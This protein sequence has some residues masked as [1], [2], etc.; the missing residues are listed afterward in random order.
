MFGWEFPPHISGGLGTACFG[1]TQALARRNVAMTFV[2]PRIRGDAA[3]SH[4]RLVAAS[5]IP[6]LWGRERLE[7]FLRRLDIREVDA[8]LRPYL[9]PL[10]YE[11]VRV[12]YERR[13]SRAGGRSASILDMSGEYGST[14]MA[15]IAR[16]SEVAEALARRESFEVIHVHD[17]MTFPAGIRAQC[18][19]GKPLVAHVHSLEFDR[20]G[21]N[22]NADVYR[23]E[24]L[25]I[26]AAD[27]II[28]V[29]HYTR[30]VLI[31]RYGADPD[32]ITVVHNAVACGEAERIYHVP[33][34][35][36][37]KVV[38]FLGRV[39]FQKGPDYFVEAAA[40]VLQK[41]PDAV[42]VMAGAGDMLPRMIERVGQLRIGRHF[43]FTGFLRGAEVE[44]MYAATDL[45]VMPSVAEPFGISPL[46]AMVY[47]IPVIVSRHAG[48]AEVLKHALKVD[49]W[50][51]QDLANKIIA[52]LKYPALTREM[53]R[54]CR[55]ELQAIRWDAAAE[56]IMAVY[57][58]L[59]P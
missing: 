21:E 19:S 56:K 43:H 7:S 12:E 17:W 36:A 28:A 5:R 32:R 25:G 48:V 39:T 38:L 37:G 6:I 49:F 41:V 31:E 59:A 51:I 47:D 27:H 40:R 9:S 16:Y 34:Q 2:I 11:R 13:D 45:Y 35:R 57:R 53:L 23:L 24:K 22:I 55:R 44:R 52:V 15:E 54:N 4:V 20:S 42:F 50:D 1:M 10:E 14:L 26:Q 8:L 58:R 33:R 29:S 3:Q 18:V 30:G 46:E